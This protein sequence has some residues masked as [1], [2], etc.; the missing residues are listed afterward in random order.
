MA[1]AAI[2]SANNSG[3][4][5]VIVEQ[6]AQQVQQP[7]A[8]P[9][10]TQMGMLPAGAQARTVDGGIYYQAAGAWYRPYFGA[11]GVYYEVVQPPAQDASGQ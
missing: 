2:A 7:V 10:G 5:T 9:V 11:N 3:P 1:G 6:P 4:D 8:Y